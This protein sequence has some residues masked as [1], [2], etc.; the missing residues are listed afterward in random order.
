MVDPWLFRGGPTLP[1]W[2]RGG[3]V[4]PPWCRGGSMLGLWG[5]RGGPMVGQLWFC[6][7]AMGVLH[8][9]FMVGPW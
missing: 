7:D 2:Y 4:V 3:P 8:G 6:G 5:F 9:A 1:P